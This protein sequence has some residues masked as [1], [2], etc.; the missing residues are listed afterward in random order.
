MNKY[1]IKISQSMKDESTI[2]PGPTALHESIASIPADIAGVGLGGIVGK[3]FGLMAGEHNL[4]SMAGAA[5]GGLITNYAV[6]KHQQLKQ[7]GLI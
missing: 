4:G 2:T 5:V 6:L 1:L 7:K 3:K